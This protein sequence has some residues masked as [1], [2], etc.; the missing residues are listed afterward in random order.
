MHSPS[1]RLG[2][3]SNEAA[4]GTGMFGTGLKGVRGFT[5]DL[6]VGTRRSV[7]S[8]CVFSFFLFSF[9]ILVHQE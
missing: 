1:Q 7:V 2:C 3:L 6:R 9:W 5:L 8:P 4:I